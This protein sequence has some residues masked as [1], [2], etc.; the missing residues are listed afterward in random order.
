MS[1][2]TLKVTT[3]VFL[4]CF[5]NLATVALFLQYLCI[6]DVVLRELHT[7]GVD[8]GGAGALERKTKKTRAHV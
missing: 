7:A 6:P 1:D 8:G 5:I 4:P 3:A 2:L